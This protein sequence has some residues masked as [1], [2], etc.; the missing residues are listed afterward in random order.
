MAS[1]KRC[2][3]PVGELRHLLRLSGNVIAILH[4]VELEHVPIES[5]LLID[6]YQLL[7]VSILILA[8]FFKLWIERLCNTEY[9][10]KYRFTLNRCIFGDQSIWMIATYKHLLA[11]GSSE[12]HENYEN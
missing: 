3:Q 10:E 2:Y 7:Q 5:R 9:P 8:I 1:E 4:F 11:C 12:Q 6:C